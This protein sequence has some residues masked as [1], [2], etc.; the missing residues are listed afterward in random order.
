MGVHTAEAT[1]TADGY[2]GVGVH[3]GA[4]ICSAGH[5][6]QVLVSHTTHDL[7]AEEDAGFAFVD[8]GEHR[9]KDLNEPHRLFSCDR[10][11]AQRFPLLRTLENRSTNLPVQPT[12]LV[13]RDRELAEVVELLR[14]PDV[15]AVT[16]T[17]PGGTRKTGSRCRRRPSWSRTSPTACSS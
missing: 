10:R 13:G 16:L 9:L 1:A 3:R 2:V 5:G 8:L 17:G 6:G 14:R 11:A 15:R 7:Q 4:R 12:P